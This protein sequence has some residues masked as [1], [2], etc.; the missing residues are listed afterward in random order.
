MSPECIGQPTAETSD[1]W[2]EAFIQATAAGPWPT[3]V[4][5]LRVAP[6]IEQ[7]HWGSRPAAFSTLP[8]E[9][10]EALSRANLA[11][12]PASQVERSHAHRVGIV[13]DQPGVGDLLLLLSHAGANTASITTA[14][15]GD[16]VLV[17]VRGP[18][19]RGL[20]GLVLVHGPAHLAPLT[21]GEAGLLAGL[22]EGALADMELR[23]FAIQDVAV[24][25]DHGVSLEPPPGARCLTLL[26][27]CGDAA[28]E[29]VMW[30]G[31][32]LQERLDLAARSWVPSP[33]QPG[34]DIPMLADLLLARAP[35]PSAQLSA[36]QVGDA[37]LFPAPAVELPPPE[38][39][40]PIVLQVAGL[41]FDARVARTETG[42]AVEILSE[43]RRARRPPPRAPAH[44]GPQ[45]TSTRA[46]MP[47]ASPTASPL[48]SP[49]GGD[50]PTRSV[51]PATTNPAFPAPA[52]PPS[53]PP[54]HRTPGRDLPPAKAGTP[55]APSPSDPGQAPTAAGPT[56]ATTSVWV[57]A[58]LGRV[59]LAAS[60]VSALAPGV[61]I[62]LDKPVGQ[63]MR[64]YAD[65]LPL[66]SG[67]LL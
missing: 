54:G 9:A 25:R 28:G 8:Q 19:A 13:N 37:L 27:S 46:S 41:S 40:W 18:L 34:G 26:V 7:I 64:L 60:A 38:E 59:T 1:P 11:Q 47:P 12:A 6:R 20:L 32:T 65:G 10:N 33:G 53:P 22:A 4:K 16:L 39:G 67:E 3:L 58:E 29:L 23:A 43:G 66:G 14:G 5:L 61:I 52:P 62:A 17:L 35:I 42:R 50:D 30:L 49:A 55:P 36:L 44:D 2:L 31:S 48:S 24:M 63:V 15:A 56:S 51:L 45:H 21:P 57:T